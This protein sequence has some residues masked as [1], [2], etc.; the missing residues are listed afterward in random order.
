MI[1][2]VTTLVAES[3]TK[4]IKVFKDRCWMLVKLRQVFVDSG[5]IFFFYRGADVNSDLVSK[6]P[7]FSIWEKK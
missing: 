7:N 4:K 3:Q 2:N 1:L 6:T 5:S